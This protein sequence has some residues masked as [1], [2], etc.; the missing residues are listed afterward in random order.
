MTATAPLPAR[1]RLI[2]LFLP[3]M[4]IWRRCRPPA[5]QGF[6]SALVGSVG[7]ASFFLARGLACGAY[8]GTEAV[9]R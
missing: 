9:W 4:V 5:A 6:G 3:A 7:V 2:G 8:I 1:T